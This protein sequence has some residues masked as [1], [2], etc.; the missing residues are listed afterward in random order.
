MEAEYLYGAIEY[1]VS[2]VLSSGGLLVTF[3]VLWISVSLVEDSLIFFLIF[4]FLFFIFFHSELV[5]KD[6]ILSGTIFVCFQG[7]WFT[8]SGL[9]AS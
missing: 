8:V 2:G 1:S 6:P 4:L 9:V 3:P 5:K 7:F